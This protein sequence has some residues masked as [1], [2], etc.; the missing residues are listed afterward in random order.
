VDTRTV[1]SAQGLLNDA[2]DVHE[3]DV[4]VVDEVV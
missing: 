4:L 3:G 2:E 1:R